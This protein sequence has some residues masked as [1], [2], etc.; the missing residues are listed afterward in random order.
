MHRAVMRHTL[1]I[2][3]YVA[4]CTRDSWTYPGAPS[5]VPVLPDGPAPPQDVLVD[6]TPPPTDAAPSRYTVRATIAPTAPH[7]TATRRIHGTLSGLTRVCDPSRS[8]CLTGTLSP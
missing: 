7:A 2:F 3:L 8:L 6:T 5:D 1:V 4:A